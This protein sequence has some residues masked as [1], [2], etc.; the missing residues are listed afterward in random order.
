[1]S[2]QGTASAVKLVLSVM[3]ARWRQRKDDR[4]ASL[5]SIICG[6]HC[7]PAAGILLAY[8]ITT[9]NAELLEVSPAAVAK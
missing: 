9:D 2:R 4:I 3:L 7:N 5:T 8:V 1:M 6:F